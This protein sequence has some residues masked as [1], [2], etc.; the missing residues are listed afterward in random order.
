MEEYMVMWSI[1]GVKLDAVSS[2]STNNV[3][4][5]THKYV[6]FVEFLSVALSLA[7]SFWSSETT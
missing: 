4:S 6:L 1:L 3:S 5:I 7:E 2:I